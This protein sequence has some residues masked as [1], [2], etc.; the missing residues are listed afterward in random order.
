[1]KAHFVPGNRIRLLECGMEYFPALIAAIEAARYEV[2]LETYIFADDETGRRVA[3]ALS[4]AA[5]RGVAV[6][7]LVDGF[8]AREFPAGLGRDLRQAGARVLVYRQ[9]VARLRLRR[10]RLRRLHR[11]LA[12][13]DGTLAFVGGI[14]VIDDINTPGQVPPRYDYAV[15]I[16]GPLVAEIHQSMHHLW[17]LVASA[18]LN[19]RAPRLPVLE[20]APRRHGRTRA[21]FVIRDNLRHRRDIEEAYLEAIDGARREI[22]IASAYF[23]PGR[24]FRQALAAAAARGVR[25]TL[26]LQGRVE[27]ALLHYATQA[28]YG[29]LLA[30]GIVIAE[31]HRSFLHAK[32]AV[33]DGQ[34]A[35]VGSSNID[36]FS[37]LL[38][39]EANVVVWDKGFAATL[40][41]SLRRAMATGADIV[42]ADAPK[43][44]PWWQRLL[45]QG[46]Y[47]LVR[48]AVGLSRYG[49]GEYRE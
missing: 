40:E 47:T 13:V 37:L 45:S 39:R 25:V 35:T 49:G 36:P 41:A 43:R 18:T 32:V 4:R 48:A 21:R 26:L 20:A 12:V 6:R 28:L 29:R 46:A 1:M 16:E 38:A 15:T 42:A 22:L 19:L 10:H 33:I 8:G 3:A 34:W 27:Y 11:K 31:Y 24:R 2:H 9:E 14:N 30:S 44:R 23:L 5:R 17:R 7:V